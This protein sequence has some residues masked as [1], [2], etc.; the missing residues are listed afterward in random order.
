MHRAAW[1]AAKAV[2]GA[3]VSCGLKQHVQRELKHEEAGSGGDDGDEE[4]SAPVDVQMP[5]TASVIWMDRLARTVITII[6][7]PYRSRA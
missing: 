1:E 2:I 3:D 6:M 4:R 5:P 7:T